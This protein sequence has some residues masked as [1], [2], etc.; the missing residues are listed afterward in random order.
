VSRR[1]PAWLLALACAAAA[2]AQ[3]ATPERRTPL[4][5]VDGEILYQEDVEGA[6]AF[7]IY[8]HEVDIYSLLR[9]EAERRV[10][11]R[12]LRREAERR[13]TSVEAMLEQVQATARP[14][15]EAEVDAWLA[16][17][18]G[19]SEARPE[20]ARVRVRHYLSETRRIEKRLALLEGLREA[21]GYRLLLPPPSPPR[22]EIDVAGAPARGPEQ[23]PVTIVHFATFSSRH[24]A[25]SAAQIARLTQ[26]FPGR[27]RWIH[28]TL[29]HERD[30]TGLLASRVGFLAQDAGRFW[31]LHDRLFAEGGSLDEGA[32]AEAARAVGLGP[33]TLER[34]RSDP[35]LLARVKR[36]LDA[37]NA[38][39]APREPT[40]FVNGRYV[41]GIAPYDEI[42]AV[43]VEESGGIP[44]PRP[45]ER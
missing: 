28:R 31:E 35:Q 20:E 13:G 34:A 12:L 25:R 45:S 36:D 30:E 33:D 16:E 41:A 15:T 39:G 17:H 5:V 4:A 3:P 21:A 32:I 23:A 44:T 40:L 43:V 19:E 2:H 7:R 22:T 29:L 37:A 8:R 9:A 10:D 38:S 42:R 6:V 24:S 14:V 18:P 1:A 11:E 27:I 26:E